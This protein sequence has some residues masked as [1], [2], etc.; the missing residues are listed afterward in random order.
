[1]K[2]E[3]IIE[4]QVSFCKSCVHKET[5]GKCFVL[6]FA[7]LVTDNVLQEQKRKLQKKGSLAMINMYNDSGWGVS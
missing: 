3:K 5:C 6:E 2:Y 4:L 1:M 7:K